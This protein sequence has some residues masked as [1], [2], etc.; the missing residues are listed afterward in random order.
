MKALLRRI[1]RFFISK[2]FAELYYWK[3]QYKL[4]NS[5]FNNEFYEKYF[6]NIAGETDTDF[7]KDKVIVDFGCGPRGSLNWIKCSKINIGVDLLSNAYFDNFYA[8]LRNHNMVYLRS[9]ENTIPIPDN[10]IDIL[11]TMNALDH[12]KDLNKMGKEIF[13][14][15]K[16]GGM[17]LGSF[18]INE[19]PTPTEPNFL[20]EDKLRESLLTGFEIRNYRVANSL[21]RGMKYNNL[22]NNTNLEYDNKK[23]AV[24]WLKAIKRS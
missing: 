7:L 21:G 10:F 11:F 13:R 15:L 9:S 5:D 8:A 22:M 4:N 16:P 2:E 17:L 14:I 1:A 24:V 20:T 6:L 18:N 23:P 19:P 12:V 3:K